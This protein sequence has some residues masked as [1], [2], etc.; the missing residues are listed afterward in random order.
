[1]VAGG[2]GYRRGVLGMLAARV[3]G[4]LWK[5]CCGVCVK[6]SVATM[7][8]MSDVGDVALVEVVGSSPTCLCDCIGLFVAVKSKLRWRVPVAYD[9]E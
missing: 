5:R 2:G 3:L 8:G 6:T 9:D 1:M 4:L 7:T